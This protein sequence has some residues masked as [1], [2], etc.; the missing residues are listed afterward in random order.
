MFLKTYSPS[1]GSRLPVLAFALTAAVVCTAAARS[2]LAGP[3]VQPRATLQGGPGSG[4]LETERITIRPDG[5]EPAQITRPQGEF[6]LAADNLSGLREVT[7]ILEHQTGQ[8]VREHRVPLEQFKWRARLDLHPGRYVVRA[9]DR[10][11][12]ACALTITPK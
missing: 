8:R 4:R 5:F 3:A 7:L 6:I 2:W 12:W 1:L 10:P 11:D 9:A